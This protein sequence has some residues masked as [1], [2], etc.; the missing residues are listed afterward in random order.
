MCF[1]IISFFNKFFIWLWYLGWCWA[2]GRAEYTQWTEKCRSLSTLNRTIDL[3][4]LLLLLLFILN[5]TI[6][7]IYL[8]VFSQP[9]HRLGLPDWLCMFF[10]CLLIR[11][12]QGQV[13]TG[14]DSNHSYLSLVSPEP[15]TLFLFLLFFLPSW[16]FSPGFAE[17]PGASKVGIT[18]GSSRASAVF[19]FFAFVFAEIWINVVFG[20]V[21]VFYT[22]NYGCDMDGSSRPQLKFLDI[23]TESS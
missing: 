12:N 17:S 2:D 19:A 8:F 7:P 20:R 11:V 10:C 23:N 16:S 6:D 13:T 15:D 4:Y 9:Y 5:R 1:L 18:Q 22:G 21:S 3:M 14:C